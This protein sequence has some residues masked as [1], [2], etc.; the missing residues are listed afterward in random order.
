M[1]QKLDRVQSSKSFYKQQWTNA[2]REMEKLECSAST[3][4]LNDQKSTESVG[5]ECD[6][7][8]DIF[9]YMRFVWFYLSNFWRHWNR[10]VDM[11]LSEKAHLFEEQE[12]LRTIFE[13]LDDVKEW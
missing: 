4:C 7:R 6:N 12:E 5:A 1:H 10:L 11:I 8:F 2:V 3:G 9:W 13:T